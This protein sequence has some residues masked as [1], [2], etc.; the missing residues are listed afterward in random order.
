[1]KK[2]D[3]FIGVDVS[4]NTLDIHCNERNEHL[5]I[6]NKS[7]GFKAFINWAKDLEIS[8]QST[9]I[10]ME[11]T[12][13]YEYKFIQFC[14]EKGIAILR[15]S[16]LEI[17]KSLGII[18]GKSDKIDAKRIAA[19]AEEK[20]KKLTPEKPLNT[21]IIRLRD[22]LAYRKKIVRENA[23]Y[24]A[25][26][27][28]RKHKYDNLKL[29]FI[30][31]D[32]SKRIKKLEQDI[33][34]IEEELERFIQSN[35]LILQ[36]YKLLTSIKGIGRLNALMTIAF[37]ENFTCFSNAR[38]YAVYVGVVPFEYSS[39]I[40]IKG[41]KRVSFFANKELKSELNQAAR[42]ALVWN[43]DL[44]EYGERLKEKKP[45]PVILNNVK[46]KLILRMFAVVNKQTNYVDNLKNVA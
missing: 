17:K 32:L 23:G 28:E 26:L 42:S 11:H 19:Y 41:R 33:K 29:D 12:G 2:W 38:A 37:T 14:Q 34:K 3:Y 25:L 22:L 45:Y 43:K 35:D 4:K 5:K 9:F 8:L 16:G 6:E 44:K 15:V 40:S 30:A 21:D 36:N 20:Q 24:K 46:F 18:R 13:G 39:G 31:N 27:S 10:V 1:M 7:S